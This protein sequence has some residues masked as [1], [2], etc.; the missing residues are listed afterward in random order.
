M[1]IDAYICTFRVC[2]SLLY[3]LQCNYG[4]AHIS[5]INRISIF[6]VDIV[7]F[8]ANFFL[9]WSVVDQN[10]NKPTYIITIAWLVFWYIWLLITGFISIL[11]KMMLVP[12]TACIH[13]TPLF[14]HTVNSN[15]K[16]SASSK[17][18]IKLSLLIHKKKKRKR[19]PLYILPRFSYIVTI[20]DSLNIPSWTTNSM[21]F[22]TAYRTKYSILLNSYIITLSSYI[23]TENTYLRSHS[24]LVKIVRI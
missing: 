1:F 20:L 12:L 5:D 13:I 4:E 3:K 24:T 6:T 15:L 22:I 19:S 18:K 21:N 23:I 2:N 10:G 14:K 8:N 11:G 9:R 16:K 7:N 17:H